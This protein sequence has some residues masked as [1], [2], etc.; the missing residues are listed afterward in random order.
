M[1]VFHMYTN[2]DFLSRLTKL[3]RRK[4]L[5]GTQWVCCEDSNETYCHSTGQRAWPRLHRT[6]TQGFTEA[7]VALPANLLTSPAH[8][9]QNVSLQ[10]VL[11][12]TGATRPCSSR[13]HEI[14]V[15][16]IEGCSKWK[17]HTRF[18]QLSTENGEDI[19]LIIILITC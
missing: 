10:T 11:S 19:S 1:H 7:V 3:K 15:V 8:Q 12:N 13:T 4:E 14:W 5:S 9:G 6:L 16:Q 17:V 18:Q 2:D